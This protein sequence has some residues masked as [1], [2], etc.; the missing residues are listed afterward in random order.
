MK[1]T[2][3]LWEDIGSLS[4]D[5]LLHV[6]TKLFALYENELEKAPYNTESLNFF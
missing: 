1:E 4:E 6:M 3:D 5:E 2:I